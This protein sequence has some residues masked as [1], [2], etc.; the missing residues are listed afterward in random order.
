MQ[1][2]GQFH[3]WGRNLVPTEQEVGFWRKENCPPHFP[4]I[5]PQTLQ[6]AD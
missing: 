2:S 3:A 5:K 4:V 1:V 6:P